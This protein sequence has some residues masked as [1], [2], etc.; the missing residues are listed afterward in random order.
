MSS[1]PEFLTEYLNKI[2]KD[3][4][5]IEH[6][7]H[8][9]SGSNHGDGFVAVMVAVTIKGKRIVDLDNVKELSLMC[10]ILPDN[11]ARREIFNS[12]KLFER[13]VFVYNDVLPMFNKFQIERNVSLDDGFFQY[14]K[15]YLAVADAAKDHYVIV[16]ENVKVA[17]Y[18]LWDKL[19]PVD[20]DTSSI[21]LKTL[22]RFH[23]LSFAL[24]DQK[25]NLFQ[26]FLNLKD[27]LSEMME[28]SAMYNMMTGSIDKATGHLINEDDIN[29]LK[30]VSE[31]F[32]PL[33][34][35]MFAPNAAGQ[36]GI[37]LHGDCWNNNF[38]FRKDPNVSV[39]QASALTSVLLVFLYDTILFSDKKNRNLLIRLANH[40]RRISSIGRVILST[41]IYNKRT[42]CPF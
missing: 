40:Y 12:V 17:G 38:C 41:N 9:E 1:S 8:Y 26:N 25:P 36:F 3:E 7:L 34:K 27:N 2:A 20:F 14:P 24:R 22:G 5:F 28:S 16:M 32:K 13:E 30:H 35:N 42:S 31:N 33:I 29:I 37:L 6:T 15:C 19:V 18:V 4:G 11:K 10:K 39:R 23:G 21:F